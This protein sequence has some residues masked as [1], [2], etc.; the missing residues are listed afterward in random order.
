MIPLPLE[1]VGRGRRSRPW[2]RSARQ[3]DV[4]LRGDQDRRIAILDHATVDG[5][6]A[7]DDADGNEG[8]DFINGQ[9]G[10]DTFV[11][12]G[13]GRDFVDGGDGVDS[14][15]VDPKCETVVNVP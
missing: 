4:E 10:D 3:R 15:G 12:C 5:G 9:A 8:T 11:G 14:L 13:E 6:E 2:P 1:N 7:G